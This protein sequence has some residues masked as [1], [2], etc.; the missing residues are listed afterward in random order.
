MRTAFE[1]FLYIVRAHDLLNHTVDIEPVGIMRCIS[2][3]SLGVYCTLNVELIIV[4]TTRIRSNAIVMAH[5]NA[6]QHFLTGYKRL[7]ELLAMA[8]TDDLLLGFPE[9]FHHA[10]SKI[11]NGARVSLLDEQITWFSMFKGKCNQIYSFIQVHKEPGHIRIGDGDRSFPLNLVNEKRN[12]RTTAAHDVTV[13]RASQH[14][15]TTFKG[16]LC[17]GLNNLLADSL[18]HAHRVDRV[19]RFIS[20]KEHNPLHSGFNSSSNHVISADDVSSHSLHRKKFT[21]GNLF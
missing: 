14:S 9:D 20:R 4:Q 12:N 18:G 5:V 17:S 8:G 3:V 19:C 16:L 2:F 6:S 11:A 15:T 10:V 1:F 13:S 7:V 21:R